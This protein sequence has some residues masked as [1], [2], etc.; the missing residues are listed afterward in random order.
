[1]KPRNSR[2]NRALRQLVLCMALG[3]AVPVGAAD[4]AMP[5]EPTV[6]VA[7]YVVEGDN[8]LSEAD[9]ASLLAPHVGPGRSLGQLESAAEALEKSMRAKGFA[10][11]RVIVPAQKP[12]GGVVKLQVLRFTLARVDVEGNENFST[13]NIRRSLPALSE[14]QAPDVSRVSRDI[15]AANSNPAKEV[16]ATFKEGEQPDTVTA[17]LKVRDNPPLA[18]FAGLSGNRALGSAHDNN[19]SLY[20]LTLGVQHANLF[21]RDQI[22][23][24]SYTTD[25]TNASAVSQYGLYYQIP[26]YGTG[27]SLAAWYTY[28]DIDSGRIAEGGGFFDVSGRGQFYGLRATQTLPRLGLAQPS[29]SL[30]LEDKHYEN[31]TTIVGFGPLGTPPVG[32]RP[33][34]LRYAIKLDDSWGALGANIDYSVNTH[35]GASNG[36]DNYNANNATFN[37]NTWRA[38]LDVATPVGDWLLSGRLRT[39]WTHGHLIAGEQFGVGGQYSV[40]G[41]RDREVAGDRGYQWNFEALGPQVLLPALQPVLFVDGAHLGG[42]GG[43]HVARE[44]V[45]TL[46]A[47][48]RWNWQRKLDTSLDFAR[49]LDGV[50]GGTSSG[51]TRMNFSVFYRF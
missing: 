33:L 2:S 28:S 20:R 44:G 10:F 47:G 38:G 24:V 31:N 13:D 22:A 5:Q 15:A 7:Q 49:V 35:G 39:Q 29:L 50:A 37:W 4:V 46:G 42:V 3:A 6:D 25:P 48:L 34:T 51:T 11:H 18:F 23:T 8:P 9:T 14:G 16:R 26:I 40:R 12:A 19:D 30:S 45:L 1:M 21:D 17:T 41:L 27:L 32:A 36:P 43:L